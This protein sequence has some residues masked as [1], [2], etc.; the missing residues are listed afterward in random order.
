M[1]VLDVP[2]NEA[3]DGTFRFVGGE[4]DALFEAMVGYLWPIQ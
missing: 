4:E 3:V 2:G 1:Q